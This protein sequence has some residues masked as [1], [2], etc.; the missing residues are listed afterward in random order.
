[1]EF[2]KLR[3]KMVEQQL[4]VRGISDPSVLKAFKKVERHKFVPAEF[5]ESAYSDHPL[6]IGSCQTISQP[7][8]VALMTELLQLTG[9]EKILEIGTGSGYQTAILA[10]LSAKVYSVERIALLA[11]KAEAKLA[12]LGYDNIEIKVGDGSLGWKDCALYDAIM[13]TASCPDSPRTLLNQLAENGRLVVPIG[14][15][16]GQILTVFTKQKNS[17]SSREICGCVF[18]PLIGEEGWRR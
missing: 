9:K 4:I 7:Y 17:V 16:F 18:V 2:A 3:E 11:E 12:E 10:E 1:M 5:L 8:I 13:V 15:A 6:P 14:E